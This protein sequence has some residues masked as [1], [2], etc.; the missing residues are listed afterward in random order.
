MKETSS[1]GQRDLVG[2]MRTMADLRSSAGAKNDDL[3]YSSIEAFVLE[4]GRIRAA[5]DS[6][7]SC[8]VRRCE[9]D[10]R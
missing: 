2:H 1:D 4:R 6:G 8:V 10:G 3:A 5:G 9:W 7:A